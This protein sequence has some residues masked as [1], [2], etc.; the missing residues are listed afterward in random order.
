MRGDVYELRALRDTVGHE[1]AGRRYAIVVQ[2][3][4]LEHHSTWAIVPTTSNLSWPGALHPTIDWGAGEAVALCDQI[5]A[6]DP[7]KRLG[8][9]VGYLPL[10]QIQ[11][12]DRALAFLLDIR[13]I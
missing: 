5:R 4:R 1:Q 6:V 10:T 3:T 9:Q 13:T 2:A 8:K 7:E 12:I 11:P